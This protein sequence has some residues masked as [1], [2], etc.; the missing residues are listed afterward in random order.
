MGALFGLLSRKIPRLDK[1]ESSKE[2]PRKTAAETPPN[3]RIH[4]KIRRA[5]QTSRIPGRKP[6]NLPTVPSWP[7]STGLRRSNERGSAPHLPRPKTKSRRSS[8]CPSNDRQHRPMEGPHPTKSISEQQTKSPIL[9]W[10]QPI[11]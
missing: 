4:I 9:L 8:S 7:A 1:R 5:G 11:R 10:E 2:R 6:R 3:R